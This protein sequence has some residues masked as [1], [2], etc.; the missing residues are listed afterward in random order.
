MRLAPSRSQVAVLVGAAAPGCVAGAELAGLIFFLNPELP[1][2]SLAIG[3]ALVLYGAMFGLLSTLAFLPFFWR[4]GVTA[5]RAI[6]WCM[7]AAHGLGTVMF[8]SHASRFAYYL[9]AGINQRLVRTGVWMA[10]AALI[11]FYTALLHSQQQRRYS[12]RS[13]VG[14]ALLSAAALVVMVERRLAYRPGQPP[15]E[16]ATTDAPTSSKLC[17]IG[18]EAATLDAIL[19]LAEQGQVPFIASLLHRGTYARLK[20]LQP[21][22]RLP[23]W[24]TLATGKFPFRHRL[25][26]Q[27]LV[28]AEFLAPAARFRLLPQWIGFASWGTFGEPA[29]P[30]GSESR[31]ALAMTEILAR[32]GAASGT[33]AWPGSAPLATQLSVGASDRFFGGT[34]ALAGDVLPATVGARLQSLWRG[35][36]E[37]GPE[38][39][40][41]FGAAAEPSVLNAAASDRWRQSAALELLRISG[42]G[43]QCLWLHLRGL[44]AVSARFYGGYAAA[45]QEG[46]QEAADQR[47]AQAVTA[48]Y[49][50]VDSLIA[51]LARAHGFDLVV[52]VSA[53]G[54]GTATGWRRALAALTESRSLA[55]QWDDGPDGVLI[56]A[57]PGFMTGKRLASARVE[58]VV[59]TLLY[60]MG[61]PVGDD[62]DGHVLTGAFEGSFLAEH[63]LT[64]VPSYEPAAA[65]SKGALP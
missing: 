57:G 13:R 50:Y 20:T 48:Y 43:V 60:A 64:F 29:S 5:A 36:P 58:D 19:P 42:P 63:A 7:V 27:R 6:P 61:M 41:R 18:L 28:S 62:L 35:G 52:V 12:L 17:V 65:A 14:L 22:W 55:G 9:P 44:G 10:V 30:I 25:L 4:Y 33:V 32:H 59:P 37:L 24:T 8:L 15:V 45:R 23:M 54:V 16:R 31:A 39:S 51:E 1:A 38:L 49:A 2:R 21:N 3:R 11:W 46:S 34:G 40:S 56:V 53:Q 26:G 47:A